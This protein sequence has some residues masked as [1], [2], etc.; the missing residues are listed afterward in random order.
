MNARGI[1]FILAVLLVTGIKAQ[2]ITFTGNSLEPYD[3]QVAA[4][5]GLSHLYILYDTRNVAMHYK[6]ADP[7]EVVTWSRF[8]ELG[9]GYAEEIENI[10]DDHA[11]TTTLTQLFPNT[12][13]I[14]DEGTNRTCLWVADYQSALIN[15]NSLKFG[16]MGDCGTATIIVDGSGND[17]VFYTVNGVRRVYDRGLHLD[18]HSLKWDE[19]ETTWI[20]NPLSEEVENFKNTI[21]VP[22]PLCNTTFE[23]KG[24]N[25]LQFWGLDLIDVSSDVYN[26]IA[27]DV[28]T[29]VTQEEKS[30]D[31]EQQNADQTTLG[32]SAPVTITFQA[33]PT[34]AV[35]YREWQMATDPDFEYL[36]LRLNQDEV[37]QEF[38][39]AGTYYW[40]YLAGNNDGSCDAVSATYT[41]D[42]GESALVCPN[43]FSPGTTEGINDVWKVSYKSIIDFHCWIY[44]RYGIKV[45]EFT[46]PNEGWDGR[47]GGK[48]VK[49][50]VYFYVIQARG[51][52]GK[53]Y[54]LSGDINIIR[55][56]KNLSGSNDD[57][58]PTDPVDPTEE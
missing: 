4:N 17:I 37:T 13:Y 31:N 20:D 18:Y 50:G 47:Y 44:N 14:I 23:L 49:A 41:V 25:L 19:E 26:T 32:G 9:G 3:A 24:D 21:V 55:F 28:N 5:T 30:H 16:E 42:I 52:D 58:D 36:E 22:A 39:E 33:F 54:K 12:G 7:S 51:A 57:P 53:D 27:V 29:V 15:V 40:R 38:T 2:E 1:F 45:A 8:N 34:D 10:E 43:V 56:K 46:D 48:L 35:V 11:G 6:A